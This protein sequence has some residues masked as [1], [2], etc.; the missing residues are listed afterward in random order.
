MIRAVVGLADADGSFTIPAIGKLGDHLGVPSPYGIRNRAEAET[1]LSAEIVS[2]VFAS[3]ETGEQVEQVGRPA[4][5]E[6]LLA[7]EEEF[8]VRNAKTDSAPFS[9]L[10]G[11]PISSIRL[12][13][14]PAGSRDAISV[15]QPENE[16]LLRYQSWI[17]RELRTWSVSHPGS[18]T[19]LRIDAYDD[20]AETLIEAKSSPHRTHVL[21]AVGQLYDYGRLVPQHKKKLIVLPA[22]PERDLFNL[23]RGL[24][25]G[26]CYESDGEFLT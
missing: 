18:N 12:G 23:A 24:S 22:I 5:S 17:G 2:I 7:V 10:R 26:I 19:C 11:V 21:Q 14:I 3:S 13:E 16:L 6:Q 1:W 4:S 9:G 15:N 20:A 8:L 25:I